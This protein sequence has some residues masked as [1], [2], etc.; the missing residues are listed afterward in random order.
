[1]SHEH[2]N[3]SPS[4]YVPDNHFT[5]FHIRTQFTAEQ[6][7]EIP[8][9]YLGPSIYDYFHAILDSTS[10]IASGSLPS[11]PPEDPI[12]IHDD[13]SRTPLEG[14]RA[15]AN[16]M[17]DDRE[18]ALDVAGTLEQ[19]LSSHMADVCDPLKPAE[20]PFFIRREF[21]QPLSIFALTSPLQD[22]I[23]PNMVIEKLHVNDTEEEAHP[24][25]TFN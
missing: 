8:I 7:P 20:C 18:Q 23:E 2:D 12:P 22:S 17:G 5:P 4:N 6:S 1:M 21:P 14:A 13:I 25:R 3:A 9:L 10:S 15:V 11:T 16:M 19:S 24:V